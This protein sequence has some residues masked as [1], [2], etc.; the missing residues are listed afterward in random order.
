MKCSKITNS[1]DCEAFRS[2]GSND[3]FWIMNDEGKTVTTQCVDQ[4]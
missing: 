4:V 1:V 2:D 3:C